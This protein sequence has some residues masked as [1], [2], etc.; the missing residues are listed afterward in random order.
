MEDTLVVFHGDCTDGFT[1]A[2]A[3]KIGLAKPMDFLA[4]T[5]GQPVPDVSGYKE[6][7]IVDFSYPRETILKMADQTRLTVIDHHKTAEAALKGLPFC[8]F[9]M[10]RS[11]AG[12]T[13]DILVKRERPWLINYVE[14]M[15]L[16]RFK[17]PGSKDVTSY[18]RSVEKTFQ[19]W[20]EL[21]RMSL[22]VVGA[23]GE[24]ARTS[25][26][27]YTRAAANQARIVTFG[28]L[29]FPLVNVTYEGCSLVADRLGEMYPEYPLAG[30]WFERADGKFQY[31]LRSRQGFDVSEFAKK[32]GGGGHAGAA[33]FTVD[34]PVHW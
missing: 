26:D 30:Y 14:D 5:Y 24:G 19:R 17:L 28:G 25:I 29:T 12:M 2:W 9:D 8:T 4:A 27:A 7:Y 20:D 31:G 32:F 34:K 11:G 13:W 23:L 3:A 16:W 15:D 22:A 1:A 10:E 18:V 6:V 33:G 21:G